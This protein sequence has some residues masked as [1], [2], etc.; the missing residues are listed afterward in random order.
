MKACKQLVWVTAFM[1]AG[2]V[3]AVACEPLVA[4]INAFNANDEQAASAAYGAFQTVNCAPED[5]VMAGRFVSLLAFNR[6]SSSVSTGDS[7]E[8]H[9][10]ELEALRDR[11]GGPWQVLDAL[12]DVYRERKEYAKAARWYQSA[13][14]DAD[15]PRLT[16]DWMAPNE[17][18]IRRMDKLATEM[19]L[20]AP[21]RE[22]VSLL[23]NGCQIAYRG[24]AL[25][26]KT[27]PIR[28]VFGTADFTPE[29]EKAAQDLS[30]C[31]KSAKPKAVTLIGHTDPVGSEQS[32]LR[33]SVQRAETLSRYLAAAG[34]SGTLK[35]E[36]RGESDPFQ[37]DDPTAYD[38]E[39]MN[40]LQRRVEADLEK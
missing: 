4:A 7:L 11:F 13:L 3:E 26:K 24:V 25:K 16:P 22:M 17:D 20:A 15:N 39:T 19:Q 35:V 38:E 37:P 23:R 21:V 36:G 10:I 27:T 9:T 6:I 12:G 29:G 18:Y 31:L 28:F 30:E 40:Q 34:Y 5:K 1:A 8:K 2:L 14:V 33:L 32:N